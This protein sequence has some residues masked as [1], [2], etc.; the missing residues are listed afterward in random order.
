MIGFELSPGFAAAPLQPLAAYFAKGQGQFIALAQA[1]QGGLTI[2][3]E[4]GTGFA[5]AMRL[6]ANDAGNRFSWRETLIAELRNI[7]PVAALTL[8]GSWAQM[9]SSGSGLQGSY[10]GN[11]AVSTSSQTPTATVT[12]DRAVPYDLWVYF[13]GRTSGGYCRVTI[14]GAQDLVNEI[15]DPAGLGF[16]AFSTYSVTDLNRRQAVK[17]ASGLTGSHVVTLSNG[18][19]ASPGGTALMLE[20]VGISGALNDPRILPPSWVPATAYAMG[21][22]VQHGGVFYT[23]R[24]NGTSGATAPTHT[25]GIASDGALDWR[26]DNRPTYPKFVAVD[27]ASE[28]EYAAELAVAGNSTTLGG[29]THGNESLISRSIL[30]DGVAWTPA[31]GANGLTLGSAIAITENTT[32]QRA[33]GGDIGECQLL[34]LITPGETCHEVTLNGT[35]ATADF[36]WLYAGMAPIVHWDGESKSLVFEQ[37]HPAGE[38]PVNLNDF[39]G[40]NPANID[41]ADVSRVGISGN[42]GAN[43]ITYGVEAGAM[44]VAGNV[45]N[46]FDTILRP[47]LD[48]GTASGGLDW[49]AKAYVNAGAFSFG[50]GD[51]LGFFNRH[52]LRVTKDDP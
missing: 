2:W 34:R 18:G 8:S 6:D 44:A 42:F 23:A 48:A 40:V 19:A 9:Q 50:A 25:G 38:T 39:S 31:Q 36:A 32:W 29:Q 52:V 16:K 1:P 20:A 41:F 4:T 47:N 49:M 22:E 17:V 11:R 7:Y 15:A 37:V 13:T 35:G 28:R 51:V 10:T 46:S 3:S 45:L 26:A 30:V 33:E 21:D 5:A 24:A 12:V 27:Y 43:S 14:D